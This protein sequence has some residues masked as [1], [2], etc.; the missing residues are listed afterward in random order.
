MAA[1]EVALVECICMHSELDL[2]ELLL[3]HQFFVL[4]YGCGRTSPLCATA[5]RA[6]EVW[7]HETRIEEA[8]LI[9][10]HHKNYPKSVH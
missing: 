8:R 1:E 9:N 2:L 5:V 3:N 6:V 10:E 4:C 7:N